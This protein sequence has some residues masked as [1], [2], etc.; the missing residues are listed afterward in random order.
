MNKVPITTP[1]VSFEIKDDIL[2]VAYLH[3]AVITIDIAKEIIRL[4]L[5]YTNGVA[6]PLLITGE[7][8]RAMDKESRDYSAKHGVEGVLAAALLGSSVYAEFFGNMFLRITQT[9][10]PSKLFTDKQQAL[11]WLEQ[12]KTKA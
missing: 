8:I 4:R 11:L 3:N 10:I 5:E 1:H 2:Y 7:G 9:T 12:F 6:Y